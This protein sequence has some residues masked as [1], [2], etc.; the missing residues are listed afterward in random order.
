MGSKED[1]IRRAREYSVIHE[2]VIK[3]ELGTGMNGVVFAVEKLAP[4]L[5]SPKQ[6]AVKACHSEIEYSRER[7]VYLRLKERDVTAIRRCMVPQLL[8]YND[9][10]CII[11]MTI[12]T[13]PFCL[14]FG[15]AYLEKPPDFSEEVLADWRAVKMEQFGRHWP[16]VQ[17]IIAALEVHGIYLMDVH[18]KNISFLD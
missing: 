8:E 6:S 12:V 17:L 11:E 16:E 9:D 15:G 2:L 5:F 13:R 14:D 18:P 7:D 4:D 10:L 1:S 3:S